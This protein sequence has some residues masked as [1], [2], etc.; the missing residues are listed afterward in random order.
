MKKINYVLYF[1]R[2]N[3]FQSKIIIPQYDKVYDFQFEITNYTDDGSDIE[4]LFHERLEAEAM[5][6]KHI[7]F[8]M[9]YSTIKDYEFRFVQWQ[10]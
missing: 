7:E 10:V 9:E 2:D 3:Y 1:I 8:Y 6:K 5:S 4:K